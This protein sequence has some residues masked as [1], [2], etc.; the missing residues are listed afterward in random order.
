M[1]LTAPRIGEM[2]VAVVS[3]MN[4]RQRTGL[5]FLGNRVLKRRRSLP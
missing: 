5:V 1:R 3:F 2:G 4:L